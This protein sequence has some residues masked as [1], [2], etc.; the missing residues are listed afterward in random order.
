MIQLSNM[1]I[2]LREL[3]IIKT[4]LVKR[5]SWMLQLTQLPLQLLLQAR[6]MLCHKSHIKLDGLTATGMIET[7]RL[8][9][10]V[11]SMIGGNEDSDLKK[12]YSIKPHITCDNYF[13]GEKIFDWIGSNWIK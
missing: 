4:A 1:I 12:L 9:E 13:S 7:R 11:D 6:K 5:L 10:Q 2:S 3:S 8:L